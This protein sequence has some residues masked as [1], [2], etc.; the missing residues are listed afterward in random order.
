MYLQKGETGPR[1]DPMQRSRIISTLIL[2]VVIMTTFAGAQ[3][4]PVSQFRRV[5][6]NRTRSSE[7]RPQTLGSNPVLLIDYPAQEGQQGAFGINDSGKI[8]GFYN[9]PDGSAKGYQLSGK[10]FKDV[11]YPG[12]FA[13]IPYGINKSGMIV[14]AYCPSQPCDYDF[15][16]FTLKGMNYTTFDF[17]GGMNTSANGANSSGDIVGSYQTSDFVAHGF[18]LHKGVYTSFDAPGAGY[19]TWA[20][21]INKQGT[22]VGL[23]Q[24]ALDND[25]GFIVHNGVITLVDYPGSSSTELNGINDNGDIIGDYTTDNVVW[26]GFLLSGGTYTV[27]DIPFPGTSG[28]APY[29]LNNKHQIVGGYGG[30]A[31]GIF[32]EFGFLTSY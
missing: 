10:T 5:P 32:Y 28:T 6:V 27:F 19:L 31:N 18:L 13:T 11:I 26:H 21:A 30:E 24:D 12:A 20:A 8:V 1:E 14:G 9:L 25:H 7:Q 2:A 4:T 17:P 3:R 16:A 22:I 29:G 15:H 23:E